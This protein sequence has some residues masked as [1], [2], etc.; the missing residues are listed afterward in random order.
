LAPLQRLGLIT[1]WSDID[2]DGGAEWKKEIEKHLDTAHIILLLVSPDFM[3]SEYCYSIEMKRAM[4]RNELKEAQV[5]PIILRPVYWQGAP[6]GKLQALPTNG[7]PVRIWQNQEKAFF[8]VAEGIRKAVEEKLV[9]RLK[10]LSIAAP[11]TQDSS[12][13]QQTQ[14]Q[15]STASPNGTQKQIVAKL[16]SEIK[17]GRNIIIAYRYHYE[18]HDVTDRTITTSS[19]YEDLEDAAQIEKIVVVNF[20]N[21]DLESGC[22]L[23]SYNLVER[24]QYIEE[25]SNYRSELNLAIRA[26]DAKYDDELRYKS[27]WRTGTLGGVKFFAK[28]V[29]QLKKPTLA[30]LQHI[31]WEINDKNGEPD[32]YYGAEIPALGSS[33]SVIF[34]IYE[35][36]DWYR[37]IKLIDYFVDVSDDS[38]EIHTGQRKPKF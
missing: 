20:D 38:L 17:E 23:P 15:V 35:K 3:K 24:A 9:N 19:L 25:F 5:I 12:Y 11:D 33:M 21:D 22:Y 13:L 4:E 32:Y 8:D 18:R 14:R 6:F 28:I 2:I 7:K 27:P 26:Y 16:V 31:F 10:D 1:L 34:D 30:M 36:G 37:I 29:R